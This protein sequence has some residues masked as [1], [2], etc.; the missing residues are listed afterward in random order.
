MGTRLVAHEVQIS[1]DL[2]AAIGGA[3]QEAI[4]L[5]VGRC[6][7][8]GVMGARDVVLGQQVGLDLGV[9]IAGERA[10][11]GE[12]GLLRQV[13][14]AAGKG[15]VALVGEQTFHVGVAIAGTLT[16]ALAVD[17]RLG[18]GRGQEAARGVAAQSVGIGGL[19]GRSGAD[20]VLRPK[21]KGATGHP[22]ARAHLGGSVDGQAQ[23]HL[24]GDDAQP[25]GDGL[26]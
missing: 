8:I 1:L 24:T 19:V 5:Q 16:E 14:V 13:I 18:F 22:E 26:A 11:A 7:L 25:D 2:G 15:S 9:A 3:R 6:V 23:I 21:R 17:E 10:E 4:R 12:I 20:G